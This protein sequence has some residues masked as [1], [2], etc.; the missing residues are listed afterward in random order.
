MRVRAA[1][2]RRRR[3]RSSTPTLR[4]LLVAL[5]RAHRHP[6]DPDPDGLGCHCRRPPADGR[7]GRPADQPPLRQRDLPQ[8]Q[9]SCS[10]SATAGPTATPAPVEVYTKRAASSCTSTS[11]RPRSAASSMPDYGIVSDAKAALDALHRGGRGDG[12][13]AGKLKDRAA[14][15]PRECEHRK[16]Q[17]AAQDPLR[18]GAAQAA[19]RLRGDERLRPRHLLRHH[20]RPV[21]DRRR[22]VPPR[23]R[24]RATGSTAARPA[25]WAGP[26][27][28][29]WASARRTRSKRDRRASRATTTSSS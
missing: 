10:A 18:R 5:R 27:R 3:R 1:A 25:R 12:A 4:D 14:T 20:H 8:R 19:A 17:H 28:R 6:R 21:A 9:T 13:A 26:S 15:G 16:T 2:D 24:A 29:R 22:P 11:S 7:H 23:L